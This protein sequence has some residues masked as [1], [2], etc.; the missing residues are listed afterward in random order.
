MTYK[1]WARLGRV[2]HLATDTYPDSAVFACTGKETTVS[3]FSWP[4]PQ[5]THHRDIVCADC[6]ALN[7]QRLDAAQES[8]ELQDAYDLDAYD[9]ESVIRIDPKAVPLDN[10]PHPLVLE[11]YSPDGGEQ[12][13]I[14][15]GPPDPGAFIFQTKGKEVLRFEPEGDVYVRG[16]KV[17]NNQVIYRAVKAFFKNTV[18]L[19]ENDPRETETPKT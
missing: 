14:F 6:V 8:T 18:G 19:V 4:K 16:E 17:D 9:G 15:T 11:A 2:W 7:I 12:V 13:M 1:G 5:Q 3:Q 10:G